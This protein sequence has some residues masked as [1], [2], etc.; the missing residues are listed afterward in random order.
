MSS[1]QPG[2]SFVLYVGRGGLDGAF[3]PTCCEIG[4]YDFVEICG[5]VYNDFCIMFRNFQFTVCFVHSNLLCE[6]S[7]KSSTLC[8]CRVKAFGWSLRLDRNLNFNDMFCQK[9]FFL[10]EFFEFREICTVKYVKFKIGTNFYTF[11]F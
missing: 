9:L 5:A 6:P 2:A 7:F 11:F 3:A 10:D 1:S 8:V 4:R